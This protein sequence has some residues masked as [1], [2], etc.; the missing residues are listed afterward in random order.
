MNRVSN[1]SRLGEYVK[2]FSGATVDEA[3][4]AAEQWAQDNNIQ[5]SNYF[6]QMKIGKL[7]TIIVDVAP[8]NQEESLIQF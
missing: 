8:I 6:L 3:I 2:H 7:E 5:L 4:K 1:L